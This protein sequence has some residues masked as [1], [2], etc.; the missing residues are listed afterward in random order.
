MATIHAKDKMSVICVPSEHIDADHLDA[1]NSSYTE[2]GLQNGV[3]VATDVSTEHTV[4]SATYAD[5]S[6]AYDVDL[7][8]ADDSGGGIGGRYTSRWIWRDT[9]ETGASNDW[10]GWGDCDQV[11]DIW[12]VNQTQGTSGLRYQYPTSCVDDHGNLYVTYSHG[13]DIGL[14]K[15][16]AS[17]T[18]SENL[19]IIEEEAILLSSVYRQDG[20]MVY[21][22]K[23]DALFLFFPT[24]NDSSSPTL[25]SVGVATSTDQGVTWKLITSAIL[26]YDDS[27]SLV[28]TPA[29]SNVR[30]TRP[31]V[32]YNP[33]VD[34][35]TLTFQYNN[36]VYTT[37]VGFDF[38]V[39]AWNNYIALH[40]YHE[41][42]IDPQTNIEY[43]LAYDITSTYL[44]LYYKGPGE[45][46]WTDSGQEYTYA[47]DTDIGIA[48]WIHHDGRPVFYWSDSSS[49]ESIA[50]AI[51]PDY[52]FNALDSFEYDNSVFSG[53]GKLEHLHAVRWQDRVLMVGNPSD[54]STN[55]DEVIAI[56]LGG[57]Q[58]LPQTRPDTFV[59]GGWAL[60]SNQ[61]GGITWTETSATGALYEV[62]WASFSYLSLETAA[63]GPTAG[64]SVEAVV[65]STISSAQGIV[66]TFKMEVNASESTSDGTLGSRPYMSMITYNGTRASYWR[67]VVSDDG[68][69][70]ADIGGFFTAVS[71]DTTN[72]P[73]YFK[74]AHT[75]DDY[76][77]RVWHST[78]GQVWT[79]GYDETLSDYA[80]ATSASIY[81]GYGAR[82]DNSSESSSAFWQMV[83]IAADTLTTE[84]DRLINYSDSDNAYTA[85]IDLEGMPLSANPAY[86][87]KNLWVYGEGL[88]AAAE[89]LWSITSTATNGIAQALVDGEDSPRIKWIQSGTSAATVEWDVSSEAPYWGRGFVYLD[90][91]YV[92]QVTLTQDNSG[93]GTTT[94]VS[95][96][97]EALLYD[98]WARSGQ[99]VYPNSDASFMRYYW[100]NQLAGS[101]AKLGS[102][103]YV[104]KGNSQGYWT[105]NT[106]LMRMRIEL[107]TDASSA[108]SSG[109]DLLIY[110]KNVLILWNAQ[111]FQAAGTALTLTLTGDGAHPIEVGKLLIGEAHYL[112][113]DPDVGRS[114]TTRPNHNRV[115]SPGGYSRSEQLGP[116]A[117][118]VAFSIRHSSR[119]LQRY[120]LNTSVPTIQIGFDTN[121]E[122][123]D[124]NQTVDLL[125]TIVS[126]VGLTTPVVFS[127]AAVEPRLG[128]TA[129]V[130][131]FARETIYGYVSGESISV[132][133]EAQAAW[134]DEIETLSQ[135]VITELV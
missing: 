134:T 44:D 123:A 7:R 15:R 76:R 13:A 94:L 117:R 41:V 92:T 100:R 46:T 20:H 99:V 70:M 127:N 56:H 14:T 74:V 35:F 63:S 18:W 133:G 72:G 57:F 104:I 38:Y 37:L 126:Q 12:S 50:V 109:S 28:Y 60:P 10:M 67:I 9:E 4:H 34:L 87:T 81:V 78:D 71:L 115:T 25:T 105:T 83:T 130:I 89:D 95:K 96:S 32:V 80:D 27:S 108:S 59:V 122:F 22:S 88:N 62:D 61:S 79:E 114:R 118:E 120:G 103:Y 17:G 65:S 107:E 29:N 39:T 47:F 43:M 66:A 131:P 124:A 19:S 24:A 82:A 53:T 111:S 21:V 40:G 112:P 42:L 48:G 73:I 26:P 119:G 51:T 16:T 5:V 69:Q 77:I 55:R 93:G 58:N 129:Q 11:V 64:S 68:Y 23:L 45:S 86:L 135:I 6:E 52:T 84:A 49:G 85:A 125:E 128:S 97:T 98:N 101:V 30:V 75:A 121:Q 1:A 102:N 116:T 90:N 54:P 3:P 113:V 91:T 2:T 110:P 132:S 8:V 106:A 31:R 33:A 36:R